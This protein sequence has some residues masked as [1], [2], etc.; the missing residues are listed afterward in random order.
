MS[1]LRPARCT[2]ALITPAWVRDSRWEHGS[3]SS[4]P[5][6]ST[7]PMRNRLPTSSLMSMPRVSTLRRVAAGPLEKAPSPPPAATAPAPPRARPPPRGAAPPLPQYRVSSRSRPPRPRPPPAPPCL[8]PGPAGPESKRVT[9]YSKRVLELERLDRSREGVRHRHVHAAWPV[10]RRAGA[11]TAADRLVVGEAVV[12][13]GHV[14]HRPLALRRNLDR[15]AER[16]HHDVGDARGRLDVAGRHRGRRPRV[17][18]TSRRS[19]DTHRRE[20]ATRGGEI[21]IH[22]DSHHVEARRAGNGQR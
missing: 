7:S 22:E 16:A 1:A 13:E 6:H 19:S 2:R 4:T 8:P 18:E 11:L 9:P 17:D 21:R 14:V 3:Q 5:S 12:A 15:L 20:G 10:S